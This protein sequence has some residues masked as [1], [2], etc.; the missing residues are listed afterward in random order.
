[1]YLLSSIRF[2][3]ILAT[4]DSSDNRHGNDSTVHTG[5][6]THGQSFEVKNRIPVALQNIF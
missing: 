2:N 1:M 5:R 6:E 4:R 3:S